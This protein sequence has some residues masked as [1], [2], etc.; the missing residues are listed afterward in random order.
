MDIK[1]IILLV[2]A[3]TIVFL[4]ISEISTLKT[5]IDKKLNDIDTII[6]KHNDELKNIFKKESGKNTDKY[7]SYTNDM[8]QQMRK[9]N[10]IERQA[11]MMSDHFGEDYGNDEKGDRLPYLS[12]TNPTQYGGGGQNINKETE[13]YMSDTSPCV[14]VVKDENNKILASTKLSDE[15]NQTIGN[16]NS[17]KQNNSNG[18]HAKVELTETPLP[19]PNN[20]HLINQVTPIK[21][22]KIS[23]GVS[24]L[25]DSKSQQNSISSTTAVSNSI[26]NDEDD[27]EM[28]DVD[29]IDDETENANNED[30]DDNN[31]NEDDDDEEEEDDDDDDEDEDEDGDDEN[32]EEEDGEEDDNEDEDEDEEDEDEDEDDDNDEED[33][34]DTQEDI[35]NKTKQTTKSDVKSDSKLNAKPDVKP[36]IKPLNKTLDLVKATPKKEI[37]SKKLQQLKKIQASM[38]S[39]DVDGIEDME[40]QAITIGSSRKGNA[41]VAKFGKQPQRKAGKV[42]RDDV[43]VAT[44]DSV[45]FKLKAESY[46]N[47]NDL[48]NIANTQGIKNIHGMTKNELYNAIKGQ[49]K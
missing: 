16:K 3:L 2:L 11:V 22:T 8:L 9:M 13:L 20:R 31:G 48:I 7:I 21:G 5:Y 12:D 4:L 25:S 14:F 37:M 40:S 29:I 23:S 28:I 46:Y 19:I 32:D 17:K 10:S 49:K 34:E 47:K 43:S 6:E 35:I 15:P 39:D 44:V 30:D 1:F 18:N 33:E 26:N 27:D 24:L 41:V 36:T 42:I 38:Q 45:S